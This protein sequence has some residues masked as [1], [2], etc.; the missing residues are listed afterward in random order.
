MQQ[1]PRGLDRQSADRPSGSV[2]P[3]TGYT[4]KRYGFRDLTASRCLSSTRVTANH[5]ERLRQ[6]PP[7]PDPPRIRIIVNPTIPL[8]AQSIAYTLPPSPSSVPRS[9]L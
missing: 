3:S 8:C 1:G 2:E 6:L 4:R 9:S 5:A 7:F